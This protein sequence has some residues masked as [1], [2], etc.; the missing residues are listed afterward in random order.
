MAV[1]MTA[2]QAQEPAQPRIST[3]GA[4]DWWNGAAGC[5]S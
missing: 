2:S 4:L 3:W 5:L 1:A